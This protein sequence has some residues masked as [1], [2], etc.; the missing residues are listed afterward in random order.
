MR[1]SSRYTVECQRHNVAGI[2]F[3][4]GHTDLRTTSGSGLCAFRTE[5]GHLAIATVEE[6]EVARL[7]DGIGTRCA[8]IAPIRSLHAED[9]EPHLLQASIHNRGAIK[10][11]AA[12]N[13][14]FGHT[15]AVSEMK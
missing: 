11:A 13:H 2:V 5:L 1:A 15:V 4:I 7:Q 3:N 12:L 9:L 14:D 8:F 10:Y 6:Y